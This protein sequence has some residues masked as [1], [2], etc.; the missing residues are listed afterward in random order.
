MSKVT[1][2]VPDGYDRGISPIVSTTAA[3]LDALLATLIRR[4]GE[5]TTEQLEWQLRPG[6]NTVGMLLAHLA[7]VEVYWV[8][9]VGSL[10]RRIQ[11]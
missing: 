10:R 4:V 5:A 1:L 2:L 6:T 9:A 11:G 3:Q 7:V 8:Q